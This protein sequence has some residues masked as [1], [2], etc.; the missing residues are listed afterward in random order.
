L[1]KHAKDY[2]DAVE[3]GNTVRVFRNGKPIAEIVPIRSG[4]ASWK[5]Q[6]M[7]LTVSGLLLSREIL[8]DRNKAT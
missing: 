6:G 8:G 1:C 3:G 2:F 4:V 7:P 5:R